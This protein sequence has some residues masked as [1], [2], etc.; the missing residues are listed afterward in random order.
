MHSGSDT[1][2]RGVASCYA[3]T[4]QGGRDA[5]MSPEGD[6]ERTHIRRHPREGPSA[7]HSAT[8]RGGPPIRCRTLRRCDNLKGRRRG[9]RGGPRWLIELEIDLQGMTLDPEYWLSNCHGFLVDSEAEEI[10]VV[11]DV[12][13]GDRLGDPAP[14]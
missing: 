13:L 14:A 9:G 11:D 5:A 3:D 4:G 10:G 12:E 8:D 6:E 7:R 2:R 1:A